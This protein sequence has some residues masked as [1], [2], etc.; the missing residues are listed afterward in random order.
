[1]MRKKKTINTI[2]TMKTNTTPI[3]SATF[4]EIEKAHEAIS[5]HRLA[6]ACK[7]RKDRNFKTTQ[8]YRLFTAAIEWEWEAVARLENRIFEMQNG[9]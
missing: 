6:I 1:M 5:E 2:N 4:S 9:L 7:L 3:L 8:L